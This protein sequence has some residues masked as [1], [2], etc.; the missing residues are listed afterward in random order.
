ITSA[1]GAALRDVLSVLARRYPLGAVR[2]YPVPVQ[3]TAAPAA[4]VAALKRAGAR[5]DCDVLLL[6][7]G[8]GSLEDLQAFNEEAVA[9]TI[10][11]CQLPVITGIGHEVDFTIAD[12]VAD[13][14][15]PTPS[16]AAELVCPDLQAWARQLE[17]HKQRL[18][19]NLQR[20]LLLHRQRNSELHGRLAR[21]HPRRQLE[22][23]M[24]RFDDVE[25]RLRRA[26]TTRMNT[27]RNSR[28]QLNARL[29]RAAPSPAINRSESAQLQLLQRLQ[30]AIGSHLNT[31]SGRINM[32]A[33][34]LHTVSPLQ[35]L[36]RG[37]AIARTAPGD[38][39]SEE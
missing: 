32:A 2:L 17:Q 21:Q 34:A 3:G 33:H 8:G 38:V 26:L 20:R 37:Y 35:T 4:I 31:A 18:A 16:A 29:R 27:A 25:I 39:R 28:T 12:F 23:A 7:R 10:A 5:A 13:V 11:A 15:A 24:Q 22:D 9:R 19:S 30:H 1:T 36:E 14:R 6:V